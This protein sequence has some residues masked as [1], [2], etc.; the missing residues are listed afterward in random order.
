[1]EPSWIDIINT[2]KSC[3]NIWGPEAAIAV[4]DLTT[5][6]YYDCGAAID[7]KINAGDLIKPGSIID[8][9]I[10]S[11][12]RTTETITDKSLYGFT[13]IGK[14]TP[15]ITDA[16]EMIGSVCVYLPTNTY[17]GLL[18]H[19]DGLKKS[20]ETIDQSVNSLS[21]AAEELAG[22]TTNL[23]NEADVI[24]NKVQE[25]DVVLNLI[26]EIAAQTHLLGL[27][28]AIEA[29]RAGE[30]GRGFNVVAEEIRKLANRTNG[31]VAEVAETL[32]KIATSIKGLD[33][34]IHQI[35]AVAQEQA[36]SM[37]EIS[38]SVDNSVAVASELKNI[39]S[40]LIK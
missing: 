7:H 33:Q 9:V 14:G 17:E 37:E 28:A 3:K 5:I 26:K 30:Q 15:I 10:K 21:S 25:S 19:S 8:E 31:S 29:A 32:S 35:S 20:L 4:S 13:Y 34:H 18:K 22:I 6:K 16:G 24:N 38:A 1:M 39:S 11:K 12:S 36:A 23:T 2:A 40:E 27:N